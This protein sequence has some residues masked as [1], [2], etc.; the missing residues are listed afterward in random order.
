MSASLR[1]QWQS[2]SSSPEKSLTRTENTR[3]KRPQLHTIRRAPPTLAPE[4]SMHNERVYGST[5]AVR[6]PAGEKLRA[7]VAHGNRQK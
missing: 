6:A 2:T 7:A 4:T 3:I 1:V 5:L